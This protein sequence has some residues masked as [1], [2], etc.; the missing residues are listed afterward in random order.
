MGGGGHQC[1][2]AGRGRGIPGRHPA[3]GLPWSA[4]S[5]SCLHHLWHTKSLP[6]IMGLYMCAGSEA[7]LQRARLCMWG[8]TLWP[9]S[10]MD[11]QTQVNRQDSLHVPALKKDEFC[12]GLQF[13]DVYYTA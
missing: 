11:H 5:I 12:L 1:A 13:K 6:P 8:C 4:S 7:D 2:G 3:L 10:Y 9:V